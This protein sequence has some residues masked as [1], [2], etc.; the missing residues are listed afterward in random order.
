MR[1]KYTINKVEGKH[2]V[3]ENRLH[4]A[5]E[6]N[7][8][9]KALSAKLSFR[10]FARM[11]HIPASTWRR[12]Y[13]AGGGTKPVRD[14]K[15][16]NR[17]HFGEYDPDLAQ[18]VADERAAQKGPRQKL[19]KPVADRIADLVKEK[20]RHRSLYDARQ[21]VVEEHPAWVVPGLRTL[22]YHVEAGDIGLSYDDLVY[23]RR[24]RRKK[25]P[26]HPA[27]TVQGRRKLAEL[28]PEAATPDEAGHL[29]SDT[30]VSCVGGLGGVFVL[31]DRVSR[32]YWLEILPAID[33]ASVLRAIAR[34]LS[35]KRIHAIKT[36]VTDNGCEFLDQNALD[37]AF[38]AP[39]YYT[40]AYA[41]YEKGGVENC[42]RILRRWFPKGTDFSK[43]SERQLR[44]VERYINSMHR[45]VLGG[46][47][48]DR[49]DRELRGVA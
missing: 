31:Y 14:L 45:K 17:L 23:G 47:T 37:K 18:R 1:P 49:K 8:Q 4:L 7:K 32:K 15:N 22:Y 35:S 44:K 46:V 33:Q 10:G 41:S 6:W 21:T 43:V 42:N 9:V 24:H 3:Y 30:V 26:A 39:V 38:G 40:R 19:L 12:E 36:V 28:P 16:P 2:L 29:Q 13:Y 11:M 20:G 5:R 34:L 25:N 27:K 48:A